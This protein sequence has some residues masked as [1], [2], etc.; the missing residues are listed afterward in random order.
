MISSQTV[1]RIPNIYILGNQSVNLTS[2]YMIASDC[3][4][5]YSL[6]GTIRISL[7]KPD[8]QCQPHKTGL[9]CS[10]CAEG[11]SV[12]FGSNKCKRCSNAHLLFIIYLICVYWFTSDCAP[13]HP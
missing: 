2:H 8:L 11:Y 10:Q 5:D 4:I 6:P 9:L 13:F 1:R 12:V 3:P 7:G